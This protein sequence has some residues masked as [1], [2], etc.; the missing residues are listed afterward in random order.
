MSDACVRATY[1]LQTALDPARVAE[2]MA[3]EQSSG[4]FVDVPGE[5]PEL[6]ARHRARVEAVEVVGESTEP[7]LPGAA[8]GPRFREA[9][10]RIAYPIDNFGA[11]LP[12]LATTL[13]GNLYELKPVAGLRLEAIDLPP[14]YARSF[15]RPAFGVA[16]TRRLAARPDGPIVGTIIKP[17]VGLSPARTADLVRQLADG[18]IDFVKDDELQANGGHCPLAARVDAV[19]PVVEEASARL[20]RRIMVAFNITD[21]L[22]AM[23]RH[24]EHVARAGGSC[25]MVNLHAAG[26]VAVEHLRRRVDLPIHGHRAGWGVLGRHPWLGVSYTAWQKLWRLAGVDHLHVNGIANKFCEPDESVAQS[27]R[28]C[29]APLADPGDVA[30]PVVSSGQWGGQAPRT[31]RLAGSP[32]LIYLAGGAIMA[33]ALGPAAGVRAIRQAWDAALRGVS[34]EDH[35]RTHAELAA[36]LRQFGA[37]SPGAG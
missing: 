16:G 31:L 33:H 10:L 32:D 13:M 17:S 21:S 14:A 11:N 5:T 30:M 15:P 6:R 22:D 3:G 34:L 27:I 9:L 23:L 4:T 1:R 8:A 35:A 37:S 12:L 36:S 28:A 19:L 2:G 24:A 20:G 26:F 29:L 18:A 25:L 7:A